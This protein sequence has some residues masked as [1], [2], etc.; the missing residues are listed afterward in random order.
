[1]LI[2]ECIFIYLRLNVYMFN[3]RVVYKFVHLNFIV[4]VP[5]VTYYSLIFHARHMLYCY[6]ILVACCCNKNI[7]F[8]H[9]LFHRC[10]FKAF[11]CCLQ[12]AYRVYL[13][14]NDTSSVRTHRVSAALTYISISCNNH[15]LTGNHHVGS[16][17]DAIG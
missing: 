2:R 10:H 6:N 11:H 5:Y 15:N 8:F 13:S 4:K 14:Y 12:G 1:M 17:L 9:G 7:T 3:A 16:S